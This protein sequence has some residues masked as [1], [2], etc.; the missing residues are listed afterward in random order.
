MTTRSAP[1]VGALLGILA[2]PL[3]AGV[4]RADSPRPSSLSWVRLEGAESCIG[5]RALA[6]AVERRL[7]AEVFVSPA[8]ASVSVEGRIE[9]TTEPD[10]WRAVITISDESG[11]QLGARLLESDAARCDALGEQ[12]TLVIAVMIDP[13][14]AL[15]PAPAAP[16]VPAPEVIVEHEIVP[17]AV[18]VPYCAPPPAAPWRAGA[19]AGAIFSLG[20][21]PGIGVGAETRAR[22]APPRWPVLQLGAAVWIPRRA[23]SGSI[24]ASFFLAHA[25]LALCPLSTSRGGFDLSGCVGFQLG[26]LRAGGFGFDLSLVQQ[27][28]V[29]NPVAGAE[30][31][32]R[33]AGPLVAAL[34]LEMIFPVVR[35]RFD[36]Q[37]TAGQRLDVFQMT[38]AAGALS[39]S[40]SVELP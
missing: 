2:M 29:F 21:L 23:G 32:R 25:S 36:Y 17:V 12:I 27:Q 30:V 14:A 18:P 34:G 24:G 16:P 37:G 40:V 10:G 26:A 38:P 31:R 3:A 8:R 35:D 9:R 5:G 4:A 15:R 19:G 6:L 39:A 20:L 33:L 28:I 11:A 22:L 7:G 1:R 13:D